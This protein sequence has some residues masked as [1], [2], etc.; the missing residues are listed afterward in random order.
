MGPPKTLNID[1]FFPWAV[2]GL[3]PYYDCAWFIWDK[4]DYPEMADTPETPCIPW[5]V[6]SLLYPP[7]AFRDKFLL[8]Y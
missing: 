3:G 4:S 1:V 2:W 5:S 8:V 7:A 6:K